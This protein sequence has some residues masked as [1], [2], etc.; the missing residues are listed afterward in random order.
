MYSKVK[1]RTSLGKSKKD[2]DY[3]VKDLPTLRRKRTIAYNRLSKALEVGL[4]VLQDRS[5]LSL[6]LSHFVD[7]ESYRNS[8]DECHLS[9]LSLEDDDDENVGELQEKCD[10]IYYHILSLHRKLFPSNYVSAV[11]SDAN[12]S[13]QQTSSNIK[14]PKINLPNFSG[15]IK[16]WPAFYDTFNSLIHLNQSLSD[17]ERMHYLISCLTG[18]ALALVSTFPV[19]GMYYGEAYNCLVKRYRNNRELAFTCWK[20]MLNFNL[21]SG[22]P[23]EYRRIFDT[24]N[25]NLKI[26]KTLDL[27]VDQWDFVLSYLVLSKLDS[28]T[29][30]DFEEA[31]SS[32]ELPSYIALKDFIYKKCEALIRDSHFQEN[33]T[34]VPMLFTAS[35]S[36]TLSKFVKPQTNNFPCVSSFNKNNPVNSLL[37]DSAELK[38]NQRCSF[39]QNSHSI[40]NCKIFLNKSV[41]E[42]H[43]C[44]KQRQWCFN[45]LK[46]FHYLKECRS[47]FRCQKCKQKHHTLIHMDKEVVHDHGLPCTS[48]EATQNSPS[49]PTKEP[50]ELN[51]S[52]FTTLTNQSLV[53]LSTAII[54]VKD[55][56]GNYQTLRALIDCGSQAHFIT[57]AAVRRLGFTASTANKSVNG[58]GQT[59]S[60]VSGSINCC[61]GADHVTYF[62][63]DFLM[64]PVI[65]GAMPSIPLNA[66]SWQHVKHL[67]LADP[68]CNIPGPIDVLLGAEVFMK[69]LLPGRIDGDVNQPTAINSIFGWLLMGRTSVETNQVTNNLCAMFCNADISRGEELNPLWKLKDL[70]S[71][72]ELAP[73]EIASQTF[74]LLERG[75]F[76]NTVSHVQRLL[77]SSRWHHVSTNESPTDI[78]PRDVLP[79]DLLNNVSWWAGPSCIRRVG[80]RHYR[81]GSVYERKHPAFYHVKVNL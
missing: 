29:R 51:T 65:C 35:N 39:C 76:A 31:F 41:I 48:S 12:N 64:L 37:S 7:V 25:E 44:A 71:S 34:K 18:D 58:L 69:L 47:A 17:T 6:F 67:Q 11:E 53:L 63:L 45:C 19:M 52:A 21:K 75:Q 13:V 46:P 1:R 74:N 26:L 43:E 20:E 81:S 50:N 10:Q 68:Q 27:P 9:I 79:K 78:C 28:K 5:D 80:G 24:F 14:L 66:S 73:D 36:K 57:E 16:Q 15:N 3:T 56:K 62:N 32:C 23:E 61:V 77:P 40:T 42:R 22:S 4:K 8:F 49:N 72:S 55:S 59:S 60:R 38:T 33:Y 30:C 2:S 70:P 54:E